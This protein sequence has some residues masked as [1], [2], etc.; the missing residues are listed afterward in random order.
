MSS[1]LST[2]VAFQSWWGRTFRIAMRVVF[3][4][5]IV[6]GVLGVLMS[7][8][9]PLGMIP[10]GLVAIVGVLGLR[11][12]RRP[13]HGWGIVAALGF[14]VPAEESKSTTST[15]SVDASA[16]AEAPPRPN[17]SLERTREG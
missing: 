3:V 2:S 16:E 4:I 11:A 17:K 12:T 6:I 7:I 5:W 13:F 14:R 15:S 8:I 10:F 1:Q 9:K